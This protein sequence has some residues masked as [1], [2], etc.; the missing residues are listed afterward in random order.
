MHQNLVKSML[1]RHNYCTRN[2]KFLDLLKVITTPS[3][4]DNRVNHLRLRNRWCCS[5]RVNFGRD[6]KHRCRGPCA[7][8]ISFLACIGRYSLTRI[9]LSPEILSP[10]MQTIC[11]A[12]KLIFFTFACKWNK[13]HT[14]KL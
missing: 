2:H 10:C 11:S 7:R 9:S 4:L 14:L 1:V 12:P 6:S 13:W 5:I 8:L 3:I